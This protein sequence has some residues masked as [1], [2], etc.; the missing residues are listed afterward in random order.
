[1]QPRKLLFAALM[2]AFSLP[3]LAADADN[4]PPG[5]TGGPGTN[6][7]NRPGTQGGPGAS[8][9]RR[10]HLSPEQREK[11]KAMS[12]DERK[13][14]MQNLRAKR[15]QMPR[16]RDNNPPGPAGGPG[17][18]WENRP[19]PQGGPGA[20]P[21]RHP[22]LSPEQREKVKAMSPD[23]RKAF[24]QDLR[25]KRAQLPR[26]RDNNPPGPTGGVGTNWENRPGPQGGLGA[27]PDRI[28]RANP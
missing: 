26:D 12:P 1:M 28:P 7:E 25:A 21:D 9:D 10:P 20:R 13:A 17:T 18:N 16:D 15:A 8:P 24:M 5:P 19:G 6:W 4:N 22:R 27:S 11:V 23:E 2:A 14:F 3:A